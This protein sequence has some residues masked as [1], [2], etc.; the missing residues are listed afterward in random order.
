MAAVRQSFGT[1]RA[2]EEVGLYTIENRNGMTAVVSDYGAILVKLLWPA[3]DGRLLDLVLGYDSLREYEADGFF[4]A[5]VGRHANRI[6]G[7][8]FTLDGRR[9]ALAANENGNNL[10]SD[11]RLGFHKQLWQ[12]EPLPSGLR[13]SRLS[14]DGE[15]GFPGNLQISVS[16]L[17][18]D[19][20]S[21]HIRY[22]G[23]SDR[24]TVVN[25]TNHS[26]FNLAGHEAGSVLPARL[27]LHCEQVL[28]LREGGLPTGRI[29]P[30][31]GT[32]MDFRFGKGLG[33]EIEADF[34][35]L[36][37]TDGYD[38]CFVTGARP[39]ERK[40]IAVLE[41]ARSGCRMEL[42]S[43]LPGLQLYS[44]NKLAPT[45]GKGGA[46]YTRRGAI[47]LET[48]YYPDSLHFP[49]FPQPVFAAGEPYRTETVFRFSQL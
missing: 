13:L 7:A 28:E 2:G 21:L 29:L 16:Y 40:P 15:C 6:A 48:Q 14:P 23:L 39:G 11:F 44:A 25:L 31:A 45:R 49:D 41:D 4:G 3:Q 36:R 33:E 42:E 9:Y 20:N 35:Q 47:C 34:A 46:L 27:T 12:A 10:H 17:L 24:K 8:A 30:V 32:P 1:S 22:E 38:H 26:F 37:L 5:T 43:D 19:D 18:L